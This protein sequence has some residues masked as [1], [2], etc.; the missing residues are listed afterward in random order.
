MEKGKIQVPGG[1][2]YYQLMGKEGPGIPVIAM[3]GGPGGTHWACGASSGW[4]G[5]GP[6]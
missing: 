5:R 6:C 4:P 1:Q 3:H 2:V